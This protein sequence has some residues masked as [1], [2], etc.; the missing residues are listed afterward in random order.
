[1]NKCKQMVD[2]QNSHLIKKMYLEVLKVT[3]YIRLRISVIPVRIVAGD[4]KTSLS[5]NNDGTIIE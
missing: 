3:R 5:R 2:N 1:M 4:M